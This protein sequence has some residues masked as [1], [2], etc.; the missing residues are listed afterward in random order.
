MY[1]HRNDYLF[2]FL[3]YNKYLF[4]SSLFRWIKQMKIKNKFI[5]LIEFILFSFIEFNNK[6]RNIIQSLF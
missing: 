6:A 2:Y 1:Q 5:Y 4:L 3:S